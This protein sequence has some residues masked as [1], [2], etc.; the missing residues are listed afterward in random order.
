MIAFEV[1]TCLF[2]RTRFGTLSS[3]G[4]ADI[5]VVSQSVIDV[6]TIPR[7]HARSSLVLSKHRESNATRLP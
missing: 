5:D 2:P 7:L 6:P 3:P 4:V 1:L